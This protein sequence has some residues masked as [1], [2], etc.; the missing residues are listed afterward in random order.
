[1][2]IL[3]TVKVVCDHLE[4]LEGVSDFLGA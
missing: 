2:P 1:V 3:M 4:G